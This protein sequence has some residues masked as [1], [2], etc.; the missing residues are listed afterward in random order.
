[1]S[2][3]ALYWLL[4]RAVLLS[5]SG[6]ATVPLL[7]ES[8]VL[9]HAVLT[10]AQLNDAIAISQVSPGPLG[11]YVVIVG[12]LVCGVPGALA[13][14]LALISPAFLAIPLAALVRR[15]RSAVL[16]GASRGVLV[17][18]CALMLV[19]GLQMAPTAAPSAL[20]LFVVA[21]G[22]AL[23]VFTNITPIA[24]IAAAALIGVIAG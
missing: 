4:L 3:I 18:S 22:A 16:Q 10:D 17:A 13:G 23:L 14:L 8:L 9:D 21:A 2:A 1:M 11:V 12:Y 15:G 5:F 7:R 24:I 19:T 20:T 6:F